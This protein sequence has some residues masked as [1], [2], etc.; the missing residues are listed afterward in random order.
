MARADARRELLQADRWVVLEVL[1]EN[2]FD[3]R[4]LI[5]VLWEVILNCLRVGNL[6]F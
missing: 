1:S 5:G 2:T 3:N 4:V 6:S